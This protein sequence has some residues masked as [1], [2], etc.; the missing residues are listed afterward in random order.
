MTWVAQGTSLAVIVPTVLIG[1]WVH[2]RAGRVVWSAVIPIAAGGIV[3]GL[4]GGQV[5]LAIDPT[6]LRRLFA[7]ML[8]ITGIRMLRRSQ[9]IA[10]EA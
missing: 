4:I 1:T 10:A 2:A 5:A 7:V 6:V 8:V 3:G 9:R